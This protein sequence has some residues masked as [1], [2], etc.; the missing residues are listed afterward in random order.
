MKNG[1]HQHFCIYCK[2]YFECAAVRNCNIPDNTCCYDKTCINTSKTDYE[3]HE[4]QRK[5]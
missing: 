5:D 4:K 1:I 2:L 3:E